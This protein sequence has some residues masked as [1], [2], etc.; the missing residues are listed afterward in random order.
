M[1]Y[2]DWDV[3][4]IDQ[5][6]HTPLSE[7][8]ATCHVPTT[9]DTG[10]PLGFCSLPTVTAF[11]PS[12]Y[13][14]TPF[15]IS[16]YNWGSPAI[17]HT[18]NPYISQDELALFEIRVFIDGRM[19]SLTTL[20]HKTLWPVNIQQALVFGENGELEPL[21]F[22]AFREEVL[23][24]SMWRPHDDLGR[25]KVVISKAFPRNSPEL[26]LDRVRHLV[27]FSFQ[28][29]PIDLLESSA[30]SWP[31]PTAYYGLPTTSITA[32]RYCSELAAT[33]PEHYNTHHQDVATEHQSSNAK[34]I[35]VTADR[36]SPAVEIQNGGRAQSALPQ[37][38]EDGN[39]F[40]S[41]HSDSITLCNNPQTDQF[42]S[43]QALYSSEGNAGGRGHAEDS[44]T[45]TEILRQLHST[46]NFLSNPISRPISI[47]LRGL[48]GADVQH[49]A[50][51]SQNQAKERTTNS[52]DNFQPNGHSHLIGTNESK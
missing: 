27:V 52:T 16:V 44:I 15:G 25:I 3:L 17:N 43:L 51:D 4:L 30:I 36:P 21:R 46:R 12:L 37:R 7:F 47:A 32:P 31:S 8:R 1:R 42:G 39:A 13:Y 18:P 19:V 49:P 9:T 28:H 29:A 26:P 33:Q 6:N 5:A 22:P 14:G 10:N 48:I 41:T 40:G 34:L 23:H 50:A 38:T 35:S 24:Q 11:V 20:D 45:W 2:D